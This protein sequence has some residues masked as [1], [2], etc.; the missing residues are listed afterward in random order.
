MDNPSQRR[1]ALTAAITFG[2]SLVLI[3]LGLTEVWGGQIGLVQLTGDERWWF[4]LPVSV[5][6]VAMLFK[7]RAPVVTLAVGFL[8]LTA[9]LLMGGSIAIFLP[10]FDLL[11]TA[12]LICLPLV[13]RA[14]WISAGV[15]VATPMIYVLSE[16]ADLRLIVLIGLQQAA[17]FICPLWWAMDVRRKTELADVAAARADAVERLSLAGRQQA[18]RQERDSLARDLHDVVA[19][20]LSAIALHS[21][22]ALATPPDEAKDRAALAQV[23]RSAIESMADMRTMIT[24]LRAPEVESNSAAD[25]GGDYAADDDGA[26]F[27]PRLTHLQPLLDQARTNGLTVAVDDQLSTVPAGRLSTATEL[28]GYRI[29]QEALTNAAK[30]APGCG[31]S[32]QL[33][34]GQDRAD[35]S[36]SIRNALVRQ[37]VQGAAGLGLGLISM[38]ERAASIGGL[39]EAGAE[40]GHWTVAARLPLAGAKAAVAKAAVAEATHAGQKVVSP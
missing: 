17:I 5:S 16:T 9:D 39:V 8:A 32:V 35:L 11:Y 37:P 27:L 34:P 40:A 23:R 10:F 2:C 15:L 7:R 19:S 6:C 1:D 28:V 13:R 33:H 31:V 12:A 25:D 22:G 30:H 3:G 24:L 14:L 38:K 4:A 21:G 29:M 18:I 36:I 20:H 26:A